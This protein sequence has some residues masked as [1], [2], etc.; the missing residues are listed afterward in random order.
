MEI[1]DTTLSTVFNDKIAS[2]VIT[3]FLVLYGGM[4]APKLPSFV[5]KLFENP[6]FKIAVLAL[7]VYNGNRDTTFAIMIAVAFTVTLN[8]ISKQKFMEGF[9]DDD[10]CSD[11][12]VKNEETGECEDLP[13]LDDMENVEGFTEDLEEDDV[14]GFSGDYSE[15]NYE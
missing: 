8:T 12:K 6:I 2:T 14:E 13:S 9:A 11:G 10:G 7:I 15:E 1:V 3:L 4:A 5:V